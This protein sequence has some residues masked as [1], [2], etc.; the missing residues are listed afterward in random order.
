MKIVNKIPEFNA[1]LELDDF[2]SAGANEEVL[3]PFNEADQKIVVLIKNSG[4]EAIITVKPG[5]SAFAGEA[6]YELKVS[7]NATSAMALESG[8]FKKKDGA[9]HLVSTADTLSYQVIAMP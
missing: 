5:D 2:E 4:A 8:R 9:V 6:D 1:I 3:L 7:A